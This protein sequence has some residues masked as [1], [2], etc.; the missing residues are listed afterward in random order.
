[1]FV[2]KVIQGEPRQA[3]IFNVGKSENVFH[4]PDE[5]FV[6]LVR[7]LDDATVTTYHP[8]E[9]ETGEVVSPQDIIDGV[10]DPSDVNFPSKPCGVRFISGIYLGGLRAISETGAKVRLM[11]ATAKSRAND[12]WLERSVGKPEVVTI[13]PKDSDK[14]IDKVLVF[15]TTEKVDF[16]DP[17]LND[18]I[19]DFSHH[20]VMVLENREKDIEYRRNAARYKRARRMWNEKKFYIHSGQNFYTQPNFRTDNLDAR[21]EISIISMKGGLARG[22]NW[23]DNKFIMAPYKNTYPSIMD[24]KS[25]D[26]KQVL[27]DQMERTRADVIQGTFRL[28][29]RNEG[30]E[31]ARRVV[32]LHSVAP[33]FTQA[34]P[35]NHLADLNF[36]EENLNLITSDYTVVHINTDEM[37]EYAMRQSRHFLETGNLPNQNCVDLTC[38]DVAK[39][40]NSFLKK[41]KSSDKDFATVDKNF[42]LQ[43]KL[44]KVGYGHSEAQN[45]R[46]GMRRAHRANGFEGAEAWVLQ[47]EDYK[48]SELGVD[49]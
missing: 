41:L 42:R 12:H 48:V 49:E 40:L 2:E 37:V 8:V 36:L 10:I 11:S 24:A 4:S 9:K 15:A 25:S 6:D 19:C 20:G 27:L 32:F 1:M 21:V 34:E 43:T 29:T 26:V 7:T 16:L 23:G 38:N 14:Q 44:A 28:M 46:K 45:I 39:L 3:D 13:V 30:E 33:E 22:A 31:E 47:F 35:N 17:K 5:V 18:L